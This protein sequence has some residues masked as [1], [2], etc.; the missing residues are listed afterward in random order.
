[1]VMKTV[2]LINPEG[3]HVRPAG[4]FSAEMQ[5][6]RSDVWVCHGQSVVSGK[7]IMNLIAAGLQQ[8]DQLEL[9]CAGPDEEAALHRAV[10]LIES[11]LGEGGASL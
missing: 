11:G 9:R 8:G 1:M 6:F 7:S 4:L 10:H 3:L 2:T 5:K